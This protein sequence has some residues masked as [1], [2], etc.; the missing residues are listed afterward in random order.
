MVNTYN[1]CFYKT[2]KEFQPKSIKKNVRHYIRNPVFCHLLPPLFFL[3]QLIFPTHISVILAILA[4]TE[5]SALV[6]VLRQ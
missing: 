5:L 4:I 2:L 6:T 1:I 3:E